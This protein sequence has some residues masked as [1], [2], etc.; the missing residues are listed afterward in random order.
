V[1]GTAAPIPPRFYRTP[2]THSDRLVY[3]RIAADA[4]DYTPSPFSTARDLLT[5]DSAA[6]IVRHQNG[7][8]IPG[9]CELKI[10]GQD[11]VI[12]P[13]VP[14]TEDARQPA[15]VALYLI[16]GNK[17]GKSDLVPVENF[18]GAF[19]A[20]AD[21]F[22]KA[23]PKGTVE[24]RLNDH[25]LNVPALPAAEHGPISVVFEDFN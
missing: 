19:V 15:T 7:S 16:D 6:F 25:V 20:S 17:N 2:F 3:F 4:E 21:V 12:D 11:L 23:D 5:N 22:V 8:M 24:F 9:V 14:V 13:I 10:N 1:H 18:G